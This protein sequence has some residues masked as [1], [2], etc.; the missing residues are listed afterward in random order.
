MIYPR[1]EKPTEEINDSPT[2][3]DATLADRVK[4][5][6]EAMLIGP[7][8]KTALARMV[9]NHFIGSENLH[10]PLNFVYSCVCSLAE[11]LNPTPVED[12]II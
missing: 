1:G 12:S 7:T 5:Q 9:E 2:V 6:A 3:C 8:A 4:E 10:I 11:E